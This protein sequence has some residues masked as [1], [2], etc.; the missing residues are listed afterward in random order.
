MPHQRVQRIH[1]F[2]EELPKTAL[3]KVKRAAVRARL[4]GE[5]VGKVEPT[6]SLTEDE[7]PAVQEMVTLLA[8]LTRVPVS[9]I[10]PEQTLLQLTLTTLVLIGSL[11][12]QRAELS[13]ELADLSKA[14]EAKVMT[15]AD[16]PAKYLLIVYQGVP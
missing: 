12:A 7:S 10:R 13:F 14:G 15:R 1:F 16:F 4:E 3:K 6:S 5:E 9:T 8:R 2:E 11:G